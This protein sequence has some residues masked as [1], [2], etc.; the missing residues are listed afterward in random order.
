MTPRSPRG[1]A[2][3]GLP[4]RARTQLVAQNNPME[5]WIEVSKEEENNGDVIVLT[6]SSLDERHKP[7]N[8]MQR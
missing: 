4:E 8:I 6:T 7:E 2:K 3:S 1:G 5:K